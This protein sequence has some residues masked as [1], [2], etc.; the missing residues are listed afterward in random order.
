MQ[1]TATKEA[2]RASTDV[3]TDSRVLT[4]AEAATYLRVSEAEVE[5]LA[6][7]HELSGRKIG[8]EWRFHKDAIDDWLR[9]PS[10]H[11]RLMRH[12]GAIHDDPYVNLMLAT[13]YRERRRP[14]I[15]D[16]E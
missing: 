15:E 12:A 4:L 6:T 8:R 1:R 13:I 3:G 10:Q 5:D 2:T 11:D 14:M 16:G 9:R 7:R